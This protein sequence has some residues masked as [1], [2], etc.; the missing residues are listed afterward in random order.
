MAT[1]LDYIEFICEQIR[2]TGSIR[3]KKMFGEFMVYVNDK[4]ILLVCNNTVYLKNI[5]QSLNCS[6]IVKWV[7]LIMVQKSII[8]LILK[9]SHSP[10]KL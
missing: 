6:A 1:T 9:T 8:F 2:D 7:H 10:V 5:L 3:F 4:P